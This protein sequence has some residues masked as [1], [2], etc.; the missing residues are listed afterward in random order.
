MTNSASVYYGKA[1]YGAP[2]LNAFILA[3]IMEK[4]DTL[5]RKRVTLA[6]SS[7]G[8]ALLPEYLSRN[9]FNSSL[10]LKRICF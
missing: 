5:V 9:A 2:S 4:C 3:P 10:P 7:T 1:H 8:G 6:G